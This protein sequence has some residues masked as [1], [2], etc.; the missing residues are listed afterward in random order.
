MAFRG[1]GKSYI[2]AAYALWRLMRDP[3]DEKILVVSASGSKAKEFVAQ[4]KNILLSMPLLETLRP[5]EGQRNKTDA[6]DVAGASISQ[7]PSLKAAGI[8]GQITGSRATLIIGDDIEVVDNSRTEE[9]RSQLLRAVNEFD[10][11]K[12]P[13]EYDTEGTLIRRGGDVLF[14]G[15][16]QT[17]ESI[18]NVLIKVRYFTCYCIPARF[19]AEDKDKVYL[20]Q[21]EDG[22][23][24][25]IL[26]GYIRQ[27]M[28]ADESVR[29]KPTDPK[30][31]NEDDL[32]AREGKGRAWFALQ[33]MLDTTLSDAERYP[34]RQHDLIVMSVNSL[35][36]PMT[37]QWGHNTSQSNAIH[38]IPN[39]G[40]TGDYLLKPLFV[41]SE[42]REYTGSV[43]FVD[44]SGRGA[45]ETAWT[46]LKI[47][48]GV[49]YCPVNKGHKGPVDDA[50]LMIAKDAKAHDVNMVLIE[51]N[52][53]PGVWISGFSPVLQKVWPGGC[54]VEE[55]EWQRGRKEERIIDTLEPVMNTHR[56][57]LDESV[58]RQDVKLE[59]RDYSLL[60]QLTHITRD[61]KSLRHD[62][63]LDSLAGAVSYFQKVLQ[64]DMESSAKA[65]HDDEL[66]D[67]LED[68]IDTCLSG[69][70]RVRGRR[71]T[72]G[73]E[74]GE[75]TQ[76]S[77]GELPESY[78]GGLGGWH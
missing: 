34:L 57:V 9:S 31:F 54:T 14:L 59:N 44:P 11:I 25:N 70:T 74:R 5:R 63:R 12:V 33:Y 56:L 66:M 8:T 47:L 21:R 32:Q 36:A 39:L 55:A 71:R 77:L 28:E 69:G 45:D 16:P 19:P 26:A 43:L 68:F 61:P 78:D 38:D 18:Y 75:V 1:V 2:S 72:R 41:D 50:Y 62:D 17:E 20:L 7:S 6:F 67:E 48:N 13:A 4:T 49:F 37:I 51:P 27:Q 24:I 60:Y 3:V 42:W 76:V 58:I 15:T 53:A 10:A 65:M 73:G 29:G 23:T 64:L 40:F 30:R 35:K 46:I 22:S 52:F